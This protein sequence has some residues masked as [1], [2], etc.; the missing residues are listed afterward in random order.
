MALLA[1]RDYPNS[2]AE[3]RAWFD[4]DSKCLDYLDWLRWPDGF[5]C[6]WCLSVQGRQAPDRRWR[7][8]GCDR[9]VSATAGTIFHGTRTP[10]TVWFS[11][12]WHLTS[13]KGGISATELQREMQLG[14]YQTAWAMLHRY[15]SVMVRP[16]RDRLTGDVEVDEA[17]LGGPEPG[18]TGRGALGKIQFAAAVELNSP[19]GLGRVRLGVIADARAESLRRFLLDNVEPGSTIVTD[20]WASYPKAT[21]GLYTLKATNVTASGRPAHEALPG[22]HLVFSLVKRWV[23]GTLH[24][25]VS[26]EHIQAYFDEWVFRFNRRNSRSRG[27]LFQRLLQQ[28]V[29]GDALTYKEL[30]KAGRTRPAPP[31]PVRARMLPPSLELEETGLPWRDSRS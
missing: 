28:A 30:R 11:A 17:F 6:P 25:S 5:A 21:Q 16:G 12:A 26:P 7:C 3:L 29:E 9:R 10:L 4:E 2:Y 22:V 19:R 27:L 13:G 1:G 23:M 24:G 18:I 31:P 15:R 14:S 20:G 8:A